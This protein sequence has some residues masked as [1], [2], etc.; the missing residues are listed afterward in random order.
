M[1]FSL[2]FVCTHTHTHTVEK[3]NLDGYVFVKAMEKRDQ[4]VIDPE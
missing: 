4:V 1:C 2:T 3:P